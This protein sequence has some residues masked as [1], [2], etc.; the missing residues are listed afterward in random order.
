MRGQNILNKDPEDLAGV[1]KKLQEAQYCWGIR[2]SGE[3][4]RAE[5]S[6]GRGKRLGTV[7][8]A[9]GEAWPYRHTR[10]LASALWP[11]QSICPVIS[12][13]PWAKRLIPMGGQ[14]A[15]TTMDARDRN[16]WAYLGTTSHQNITTVLHDFPS[17]NLE[18][19]QSCPLRG[20]NIRSGKWSL[21]LLLHPGACFQVIRLTLKNTRATVHAQ[22]SISFS[23][24]A[25]YFLLLFHCL[26]S[27]PPPPPPS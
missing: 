21:S 16:L 1:F 3:R 8:M 14:E 10:L 17:A 9:M 5:A 19:P 24:H 25:V 13:H 12:L 26:W 2:D 7:L 4:V 18:K 27:C 23:L 22:F 11:N 20:I 6:E 15:P